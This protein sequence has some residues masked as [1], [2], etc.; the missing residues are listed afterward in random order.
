VPGLRRRALLAGG[1]VGL[2]AALGLVVVA[3]DAPS[4]GDEFRQP[5]PGALVI[6]SA[7]AGLGSLL[8]L[9]RRRYLLVRLTAGLAV[10]AVLWAWAAGQF[11]YLLPPSTAVDDVAAIPAVLHATLVAVAVGAAVLA[12]SMWWLFRLFQS[13]PVR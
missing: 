12:P 5:L 11:P 7:L 1:G 3:V 4:L 2:L 10:A 9:Y 6:L 8:L 13:D